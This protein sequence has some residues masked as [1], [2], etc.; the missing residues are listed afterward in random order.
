[1]KFRIGDAR[2]VVKLLMAISILTVAGN[3]VAQS[4]GFY[5]VSAYKFKGS[6]QLPPLSN[7]PADQARIL[8]IA[9]ECVTKLD[10]RKGDPFDRLAARKECEAAAGSFGTI[11]QLTGWHGYLSKRQILQNGEISLEFT[12]SNAPMFAGT[13][14]WGDDAPI[15]AW[16]LPGKA[17]ISVRALPLEATPQLIAGMKSTKLG[18]EMMFSGEVVA[19]PYFRLEPEK[20]ASQISIRITDLGTYP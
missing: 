19:T 4:N 20:D 1:M 12:M 16:S 17:M 8:K 5:V 13:L 14:A 2:K 11:T 10:Y 15:L 3:G 9:G 7:L 18:Q 6:K